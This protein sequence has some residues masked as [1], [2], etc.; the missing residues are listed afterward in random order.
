M[1][2][3]ETKTDGHFSTFF[4]GG[5]VSRVTGHESIFVTKI[6]FVSIVLKLYA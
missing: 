4:Q 2:I 1:I 3:V 6:G 5:E